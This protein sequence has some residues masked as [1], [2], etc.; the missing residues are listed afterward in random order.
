MGTEDADDP[1]CCCAAEVGTLASRSRVDDLCRCGD[2]EASF[3]VTVLIPLL[4]FSTLSWLAPS[5]LALRDVLVEDSTERHGMEAVVSGMTLDKDWSKP[6]GK[7]DG[8][9]NE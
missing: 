4:V 7:P 3:N 5:A 2:W 8:F 9:F 1:A 6:T